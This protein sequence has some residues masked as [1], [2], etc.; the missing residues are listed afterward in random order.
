ML[1]VQLMG[2]NPTAI[3][4]DEYVVVVE[5]AHLLLNP[6]LHLFI[7]NMYTIMPFHSLRTLC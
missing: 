3:F 6:V 2:P 1:S 7:C 5:Q 4:G